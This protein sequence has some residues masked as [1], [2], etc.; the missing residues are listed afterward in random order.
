MN[1]WPRSSRHLRKASKVEDGDQTKQMKKLIGNWNSADS[2]TNV[3]RTRTIKS[4]T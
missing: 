4:E 3:R 2:R 1:G